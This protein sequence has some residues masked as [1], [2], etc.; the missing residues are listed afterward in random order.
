MLYEWVG[1]QFS[2]GDCYVDKYKYW[3]HTLGDSDHVRFILLNHDTGEEK[4]TDE[5]TVK[6][7]Q[8]HDMTIVENTVQIG[9][10]SYTLTCRSAKSIRWSLRE[11]PK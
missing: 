6:G 3:L 9:E 7:H 8:D 1:T 5:Q 10:G 4:T 11:V 2:L